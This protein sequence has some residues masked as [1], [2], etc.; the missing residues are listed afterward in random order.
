MEMSITTYG[1]VYKAACQ[2]VM[3]DRIRV[4]IPQLFASEMVTVFEFAGPRPEAGD[5]GWISFEAGLPE[6]PIWIGSES[7]G[8]SGGG[9]DVAIWPPYKVVSLAVSVDNATGGN[10]DVVLLDG[11]YEVALDGWVEILVGGGYGGL[12]TTSVN[13]RQGVL[14]ASYLDPTGQPWIAFGYMASPAAS[15]WESIGDC[16]FS[17]PVVS[18]QFLTADWRGNWSPSDSPCSFRSNVSV[19]FYSAAGQ[20]GS[21]GLVG[22][23][24]PPG[25]P[26]PAGP[27]GGTYE[28]TLSALTTSPP[29][30]GEY[31]INNTDQSA[32]TQLFVS[33]ESAHGIDVSIFLAG[34]SSGYTW[35]LYE[36]AN[37]AVKMEYVVTSAP[38]DHGTWMEYTV[39]LEESDGPIPAGPIYAAGTQGQAGGEAPSF[40]RHIQTVPATTWVI[41]HNLSF[42]PNVTVVDSSGGQVVPGTVAYTNSTTVTLTFSSALGG[43][44]YLS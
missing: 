15:T 16:A 33:K 3:I 39:T 7:K 17:I 19:K 10:T 43:E 40:Y 28:F 8:S 25:P 36:K 41:V 32:A 27:P 44:A 14:S 13:V 9:S 24:G 37:P 34:H 5:E 26:G 11:S 2:E 30:L 12:S 35:Y 21:I 18:G 38:I 1:G 23:V 4:Q 22:P 20:T 29:A 31:R 6:H 42:R